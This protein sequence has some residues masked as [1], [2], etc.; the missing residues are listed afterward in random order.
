M[1]W[2]DWF[3]I[4]F[5][6]VSLVNG[7]REGFVRMGIGLAA[8]VG[9]FFCAS[10][11]GGM[12]AGALSP[13]IHSRPL[14]SIAAFLTIFL[15]VIL[16]GA[17]VGTVM[18]RLLK[19]IGL[20]PIDRLLG[21][22]FGVARGVVVIVVVAMVITA[23]APKSL[24]GAIRRSTLAPYVFESSR[25]VSAATPYEIRNGFD[26]AYSEL[27]GL[28]RDAFRRRPATERFDLRNE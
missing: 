16:A 7:L 1:N 13:Y 19:I 18:T 24:P 22:A 8:L 25:V 10:W 14:A 15:G 4:V 23:F 26:R 6:A 9:G 17:L 28:W 11:F 3:L 20:S 12:L 27:K 5:L 21:G 2:L